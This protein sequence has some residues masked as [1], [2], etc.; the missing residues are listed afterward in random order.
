MKKNKRKH[1][2]EKREYK[3]KRE[4]RHKKELKRFDLI[5]KE[6][7]SRAAS[8][9]IWL[10]TGRKVEANSEFFQQK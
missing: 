1:Q 6:I 4:Y 8:K 7:I 3:Q 9:I 10:A 2:R 5:L